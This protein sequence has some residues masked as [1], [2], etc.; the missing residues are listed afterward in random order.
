MIIMTDADVDAP[1]PHLA[2]DFLLSANADIIERGHLH[3]QPP[4]YKVTK[5]KREVYVKDDA[6]LNAYLLTAALDRASLHVNADAPGVSGPALEALARKYMEVDAL[7]RR[8]A[9]RYDELVLRQLLYMPA[10]TPDRL[11]DSA[12]LERWVSD[13]GTRLATSGD[14][15]PRYTVQLEPGEVG[16]GQRI[17]IARR[18]HGVVTRKHPAGVLFHPSIAA[19][20]ARSGAWRPRDGASAANSAATWP[21][22]RHDVAA[23]AGEA[24]DDQRY[25]GPAMN[26]EQPGTPPSILR[27]DACWRPIEDAVSAT[28]SSR[29]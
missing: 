13:L 2:A 23:G 21:Q 26:P 25:K 19:P 14:L 22:R 20:Q 11:Q 28:R 10:V 6:E 27:R 29:R 7:I 17:S 24:A 8:W 12:W 5:G 3:A 4:L 16:D 15:G 18:H 1:H 9:R